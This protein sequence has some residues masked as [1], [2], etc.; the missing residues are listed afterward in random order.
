MP[1]STLPAHVS[2]SSQF[3]AAFAGFFRSLSLFAIAALWAAASGLQAA[4][5]T[6]TK[7]SAG[8]GHSLFLKSDGTL[9]GM[10]GTSTG[11]LGNNTANFY[12]NT[13]LQI[14][15]GSYIAISAGSSNGLAGFSATYSLFLKSDGTLWTVG[16]NYSGALGA[17][18]TGPLFDPVQIASNVTAISAGVDDAYFVKSD[19]SLWGMGGNNYGELGIGNDSMFNLPVE[20]DVPVEIVPSGVA[21]VTAGYDFAF[22][23]KTDHTLWGMGINDAGQLG[24]IAL[25]EQ[26]TPVQID[27]NVSAVAAG[28]AH[29]LILHTNGSLTGLGDDF[30]GDLGDGQGNA[31][32]NPVL[33]AASNVTAVACGIYSSFFLTANGTL[34]GMGDGEYGQ[35]GDGGQVGSFASSTPVLVSTS[36]AAVAAGMEHTLLIDTAC[37]LWGM[38]R[39]SEGQLGLPDNADTSTI[40]LILDT[41]P[42]ISAQPANA[43]YTAGGNVSFSVTAGGTGLLYQ[44]QYSLNGVYWTALGDGV[45]SGLG[46]F[47]GSGTATLRIA[48]ITANLLAYHF[49]VTVSNTGN[50]PLISNPA[51]IGGTKPQITAQ[52]ANL[53]APYAGADA[54]TTVT[55]DGLPA[56][57][58]VW[59]F[60]PASS[61]VFSNISI[62]DPYRIT[63]LFGDPPGKLL[64]VNTNTTMN[65]DQYRCFIYNSAG[66]VTS[67]TV[68]FSIGTVKPPKPVAPAIT[69]QPAN[70]TVITGSL[71]TF[72]LVATGTPYPTFAWQFLLPGSKTWTNLSD[73]A[74]TTGS[75]TNQ[76]SL[77]NTYLDLS[78]TQ[79]RCVVTNSAKSVTSKSG[80]L[81]VQPSSLTAGSLGTNLDATQSD[82][83]ITYV[84]ANQA[85]TFSVN[86]SGP[87]TVSYQF[88]Q[89]STTVSGGTDSKYAIKKFGAANIGNYTVTVKSVSSNGTLMITKGPIAIALGA[90]PKVV[91]SPGAQSVGS[92]VNTSFTVSYTANPATIQWQSSTDGKNWSNLA[93]SGPYSGV[94]TAT[95]GVTANASLNGLQYQAVIHNIFNTAVSKPAKLTVTA[96]APGFVGN[97]TITSI[98]ANLPILG[99]QTIKLTSAAQAY[100]LPVTSTGLATL[101]SSVTTALLKFTGLTTVPTITVNTAKTTATH[102]EAAVT[103]TAAYNAGGIIGTIKITDINGT[104]VG[105]LTNNNTI[106][107]NVNITGTATLFGTPTPGSAISL[108]IIMTKST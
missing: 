7:I 105:N 82:S 20:S 8:V 5:V 43:S 16:S 18:S 6:V 89:G 42:M 58:F 96:P 67:N 63:G 94:T 14:L 36:V 9:W 91:A 47:T 59:Q 73:G 97:Y 85:V 11:A 17:N 2:S 37:R 107:L 72:S 99:N 75:A 55:A 1:C 87:G 19:G 93:N 4:S 34:Y 48:N 104:I 46:N 53:N 26:V 21:S 12:Q 65:G 24:N 29:T 102:Y 44:W 95:L 62:S 78:G 103:G 90:P 84:L 74:N 70:V 3:P 69:T 27:T 50:T 106:T 39:D 66:N 60:K 56:P 40:S 68:T 81:I 100:K 22:F 101:T 57:F 41:S 64:I 45:A 28:Y 49:R 38:G 51:V 77:A 79:L 30:F 31:T 71:A 13:P 88:Y 76:L 86:A 92:G 54:S 61:S 32:F 83:G 98:N 25:S 52:P 108:V 35:F 80:F 33:I 23:I 10:G 15:S